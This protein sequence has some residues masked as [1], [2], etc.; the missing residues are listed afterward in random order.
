MVTDLAMLFGSK[1]KMKGTSAPL[2]TEA[3]VAFCILL[4][5]LAKVCRIRSRRLR[6]NV[7]KEIFVEPLTSLLK[8]N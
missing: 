6:Q 4:Q 3:A 5:L 1:P 2:A 8:S 7:I